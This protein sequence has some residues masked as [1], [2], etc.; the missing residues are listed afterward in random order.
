MP[1][2]LVEGTISRD[3]LCTLAAECY[4]DLVK[5]VV[6]LA[7]GVMVVGGDLHADAE[8]MLLEQGSLQKDLWGINIYPSKLHPEWIEYDSMINLRPSQGNRSRGVEDA[9]IRGRIVELIGR[10]TN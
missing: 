9:A 6:D 8:A 3:E 2:R 4:G 7:R 10:L 5:V 1:M